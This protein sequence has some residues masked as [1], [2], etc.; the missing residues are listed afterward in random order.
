MLAKRLFT[1]KNHIKVLQQL[2]SKPLAQSASFMPF[3][4][5]GFSTE[6]ETKE[7]QGE[8]TSLQFEQE[9]VSAI[10]E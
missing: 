2:C 4:A 7:V 9:N 1:N 6:N 8:D 10:L 3:A 5:R